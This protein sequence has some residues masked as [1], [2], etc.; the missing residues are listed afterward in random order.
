MNE[1]T[2][3]G[4]LTVLEKTLSPSGR[5]EFRCRCECGAIVE[6]RRD[7][8]RK[9][10]I[11]S[12]G[13]FKKE[14]EEAYRQKREAELQI[15][16]EKQAARIELLKQR[17]RIKSLLEVAL[18]RRHE[19]L[20][21]FLILSEPSKTDPLWDFEFF[22]NLIGE[23]SCHYCKSELDLDGIPL[24]CKDDQIG[25][26]ACNVVPSCRTCI[27]IRHAYVNPL[28]SYEEMLLLSPG[29]EEIKLKRKCPL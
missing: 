25:F 4:R 16:K 22:K 29:L 7:K 24:D 20:K 1:G 21:H 8:L 15:K 23:N 11:V 6:V 2:V 18:E 10:L 13:C 9:G 28:L 26:L 27:G 19:S 5:P 14:R 17:P 12:C 3:F